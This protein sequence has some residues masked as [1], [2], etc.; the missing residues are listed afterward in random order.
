MSRDI[1]AE[2]ILLEWRQYFLST[3]ANTPAWKVSFAISSTRKIPRN[4]FTPE[5]AVSRIRRYSV[6]D[7]TDVVHSDVPVSSATWRDIARPNSRG[8]RKSLYHITRMTGLMLAGNT[9]ESSGRAAAQTARQQKQFGR[10]RAISEAAA[11]AGARTEQSARA[12]RSQLEGRHFEA[13]LTAANTRFCPIPRSRDSIK[14]DGDWLA[15][16]Q[17]NCTST[18]ISQNANNPPLVI[19]VRTRSRFWLSFF[20]FF[21]FTIFAVAKVLDVRHCFSTT[22]QLTVD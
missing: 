6:A 18:G 16:K 13:Y 12:A 21:Y 10:G 17:V 9:G 15:E 3:R 4:D 7:K 22:F 14:N 19:F 20:F 5:L 1:F 8:Y 11:L 2:T